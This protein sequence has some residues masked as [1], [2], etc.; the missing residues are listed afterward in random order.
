[1]A[2]TKPKPKTEPVDENAIVKRKTED[3]I[4]IMEIIPRVLIPI[5]DSKQLATAMD[6][7]KAC[8]SQAWEK[9]FVVARDVP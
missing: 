8:L 7:I 4:E 2:K 1:M 9:G 6:Q 5:H 3:V